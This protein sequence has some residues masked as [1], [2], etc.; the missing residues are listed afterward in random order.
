MT[1]HPRS[2]FGSCVP[3]LVFC[4][5][6]VRGAAAELSEVCGKYSNDATTNGYGSPR[7]LCARGLRRGDAGSDGGAE[8]SLREGD[9]SKAVDCT[10]PWGENDDITAT[11]THLL[12]CVQSPAGQRAACTLIVG[13]GVRLQF[14]LDAIKGHARASEAMLGTVEAFD[15]LATLGWR[16]CC[17]GDVN[18]S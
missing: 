16:S 2:I 11:G 4:A 10:R 14:E 17:T 3:T 9:H 6:G 12:W 8:G 18:D 15:T 13:Q 1:V 7:W 5:R